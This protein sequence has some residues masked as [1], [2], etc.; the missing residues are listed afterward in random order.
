MHRSASSRASTSTPAASSRAPTSSTSATPATRSSWPQRYDAEGADELVFLDITAT[1]EQAR[2]DRRAGAAHGR[3]RLHPV[4]DRR[5]D[6]LGRT[7]RRR[8]STPAP[9]R[10]RSTRPRSRGRSCSTSWPERSARSAWCC[11][12]TR[13]RRTEAA[14][15]GGVRR[16]RAHA[17]RPRRGR[18][19]ARGRRARGGGDPAD[20]HGPRRHEDGYDLELT[21]AVA[22]AVDVPVIAS[23]G[24]GEL[25][26][27]VEALRGR[28][29]R[30]ARR[31]DLPL[32]PP[33]GRRG[34]GA[35]GR[36][37]RAG[38]AGRLT[39]PAICGFCVVSRRGRVVRRG[40]R[41]LS[42]RTAR[43]AASSA[44]RQAGVAR[45]AA[46]RRGRGSRPGRWRCRRR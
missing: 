39:R 2:H 15:L 25:D 5:R 43:A 20:A 40:L 19:G 36:G 16:R 30:G 27:L 34:Q 3:R 31:V 37:R 10:S 32:R 22:E 14:R 13:K 23:G 21:R 42:S 12:S 17:D 26:H 8:C 35:S 45:W 24:A 29:R 11:R 33:H 1:H 38:A 6:P 9:T 18:V 28:R 4:H 41:R 7:T 44:L 46:A